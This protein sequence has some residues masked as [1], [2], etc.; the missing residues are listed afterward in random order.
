[1][2]R[3]NT[4]LNAF[5]EVF[6]IMNRPLVWVPIL[7]YLLLKLALILIYRATFL[8]PFASL[9][10]LFVSSDLR[11]TLTHYPSD[12]IEMPLVLGRLAIVLDVFLGVVF[13]GATMVLFADVL[14]DK[15][16]SLVR[17]FAA[18]LGRYRT[19][20]G[21]TLVSTVVWVAVAQ[22]PAIIEH[23]GGRPAPSMPVALITVV[24]R[25]VVQT[26]FVHA[27]PLALLA[28]ASFPAAIAGSL[29]WAGRS[30]TQSLLLVTVPLLIVV[31]TA[32]MGLKSSTLVSAFAPEAMIPLAIASEIAR[33]LSVLLFIGGLTVWFIRREG[34]ESIA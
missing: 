26:F 16:L 4:A 18:T 33:W 11:P 31:P 2:R 30:F 20:V 9:W 10:G 5:Y 29:R 32:L 15:P 17:A 21:V 6:N 23:P 14:R 24:L 8:G 28:N 27:L 34:R 7:A 25:L 22:L 13:Q 3:Q 1:M 12:L 19:I